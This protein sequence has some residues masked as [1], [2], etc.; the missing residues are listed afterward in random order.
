MNIAH[1]RGHKLTNHTQGASGQRAISWWLQIVIV[2]L[3]C[4]RGWRAKE[5][6][7][8]LLCEWTETQIPTRLKEE[9]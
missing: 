3:V 2:G 4:L 7:N 5:T 9:D 6:T 1:L 8:A